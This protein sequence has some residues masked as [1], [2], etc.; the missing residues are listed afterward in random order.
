MKFVVH[1]GDA[2]IQSQQLYT[3]MRGVSA[4]TRPLDYSDHPETQTRCAGKAVT[5]NCTHPADCLDG[6]WI[7]SNAPAMVL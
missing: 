7:V 2:L 3:Q 5:Q 1:L 6:C 4:E